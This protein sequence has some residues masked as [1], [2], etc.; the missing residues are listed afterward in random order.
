MT[1]GNIMGL[2]GTVF[3]LRR[4]KG[5]TQAEVGIASGLATSYVSRIENGRLQP[6]LPTLRRLAAALGVPVSGL[7]P[8]G[9]RPPGP[10]CCPVSTSGQCIGELIRGDRG[11]APGDA[12]VRYGPEEIRLLRMADYV[13]LCG[14][15]ETRDALAVVLA[16]FVDRAGVT[17]GAR[18]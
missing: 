18:S 10:G 6:T 8:G 14:T 1:K 13:V 4:E 2:G 11:R 12:K 7:F 15:K 5:F 9:G 3:R 16:A 17:S